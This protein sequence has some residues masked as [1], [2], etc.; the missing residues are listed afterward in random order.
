MIGQT[1]SHYRILEKL[2]EG[3]MG[4]VYLAEDTLLGRHVAIKTLTA[5]S[6]PGRQHLRTR[7]LREARAVSSLAH[8]HI[9]AVYDY[10]ETPDGSPFIV[11]ELVKGKTLAEVLREKSLTL[12]CAV[13]I[14]VA[15]AEALAAAHGEGILHRDIKPTNVAVSEKGEVKVLDFGLAKQM[16]EEQRGLEDPELRGLLETQTREGVVVGTPMYLS[17]EQAMGVCVDG[18]SDIFSLGTLLYECVTGCRAFF[19]TSP[20]E[21]CAQVIR[22]DPPLPSSLNPS[23]PRELDRVVMKALAKKAEARHQSAEELMSDL[24]GVLTQLGESGGDLPA[25]GVNTA[26]MDSVSTRTLSALSDI[27]YKPRLPLGALLAGLVVAALTAGVLWNILRPAPYQP[28]PEARRLFEL[29]AS[30]LRDGT[31]YKASKLL[32]RAVAADGQ[33]ALARARLAEAWMELDYTDR[34]K[35]ELLIV[36]DR[37]SP[38][39]SRLPEL[40]TLYV[41]AV[42]ATVT[43]DLGRAVNSYSEITRLKHEDANSHVDLG[44]AYEKTEQIDKAIESYLT[45]TRMDSGNSAAFLRLGM[46]YVRKEDADGARAAFDRAEAL[47]QDSSMEGAAEVIYQ[48]GVFAN[49]KGRVDE[50]RAQ[51]EKALNITRI[52][53]NT[54][55]QIKILLELA[56]LA[57][58]AGNTE[59]ARQYTATAVDLAKGEGLENLTT[60]GLHDLGYAFFVGRSYADAEQYFKQALDFAQRYKGRNNEARVKLSLGSLY[61][62][63][64]EPEKGQPYVEQALAYYRGGGYRKEVS[65]CLMMIGRAMLLKGD[66]GAAH[67]TFDEQLRLAKEVDDPAQVARTQAE[68]GSALAKQEVYPEALRHFDESYNIS[69]SLNN[70]LSAGF[71]LLNRGDMFARLGR[72]AEA[73]DSLDKLGLLLMRLSDDNNNKQVW[74]AWTF[75]IRARIALSLRK[76]AEAEVLCRRAMTSATAQNKNTLA[77]AKALLGLAKALSGSPSSGKRLCE[78][79]VESAVQTGD[80]R[81][82]SDVRLIAAEVLLESGDAAAARDAALLAQESFVKLHKHESEWRA[83]LIAARASRRLGDNGT[84]AEQLANT[85][86]LLAALRDQWGTEEYENYTSRADIAVYRRQ[87]AELASTR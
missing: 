32:E 61:V 37:L 3:G 79:A 68:I 20:V 77:V 15:V 53:N 26:P 23:V 50:A 65:K 78:E 51:L 39:R 76:P 25:V 82:V 81:L 6:Q 62:Q 86:K 1:I 72:Y 24:R 9:A 80:A 58:S 18:R 83:W 45:A 48:R 57:Y 84:A 19:G 4:I 40:D 36:T 13:E 14:V 54:H 38:E 85:D 33:F 27:F 73:E 22:E 74:T 16:G 17:P 47:Y 56:R 12:A 60:K 5:G 41:N 7:F 44:R 11:M 67:R 42:T 49:Q 55:Q 71:S 43:G 21:I 30:A 46:L 34:A 70:P 10:G 75:L 69:Q 87:L 31:Y 35:D 63:Q 8:R 28:T 52:N 29:G 64:E 59:Q 66:S 2:G